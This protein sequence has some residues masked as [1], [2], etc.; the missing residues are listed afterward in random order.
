MI[1]NKNK[2]VENESKWLRW[3][4]K[5]IMQ[6]NENQWS[7]IKMINKSL[8]IIIPT[9]IKTGK[10]QTLSPSLSGFLLDNPAAAVLSD[11]VEN[12]AWK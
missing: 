12:T 3:T 9:V 10:I 1:D 6:K 4:L 7:K 2:M 11:D 8:Q 5:L